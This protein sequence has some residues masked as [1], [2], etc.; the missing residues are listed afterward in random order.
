[1]FLFKRNPHF[2]HFLWQARLGVLGNQTNCIALQFQKEAGGADLHR[3]DVGQTAGESWQIETKGNPGSPGIMFP[4]SSGPN[5]ASC[6]YLAPLVFHPCSAGPPPTPQWC[7]TRAPLVLYPGLLPATL[8]S[9]LSSLSLS[10]PPLFPPLPFPLSP[11]LSLHVHFLCCSCW[12][13]W[14]G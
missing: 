4:I 7:S 5:E 6:S 2:Q 11:T 9:S 14:Q 12:D 3:P 10:F 13:S 1:M 8:S